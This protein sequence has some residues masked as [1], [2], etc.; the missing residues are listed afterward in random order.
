[1]AHKKLF[2]TRCGNL[3]VATSESTGQPDQPSTASVV[4]SFECQPCQLRFQVSQQEMAPAETTRDRRR[5]ARVPVRVPVDLECGDLAAE[6]TVTDISK[7]G[8]AVESPQPLTIGQLLRLKFP[9]PTGSVDNCATQKIATVQ[10][11]R[12]QKAGVKFL[13]FTPE[14]Q[15]RLTRT[16][17]KSIQF[18]PPPDKRS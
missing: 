18:F 2:C 14:E 1:M 17:T 10:N 7:S 6:A 8:C 9:P 3:L 13:A 4:Y 5:T 16:V 11:L 12:G 15:T